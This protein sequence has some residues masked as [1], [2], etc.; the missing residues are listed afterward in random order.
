M[1]RRIQKLRNKLDSEELNPMYKKI[2]Y[3]KRKGGTQKK[4][5]KEQS[6]LALATEPSTCT[7]TKKKRWP[8]DRRSKIIQNATHIEMKLKMNVFMRESK[9]EQECNTEMNTLM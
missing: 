9:I 3:I 5:N 1:R 6:T 4:R 8:I 2:K 7:T